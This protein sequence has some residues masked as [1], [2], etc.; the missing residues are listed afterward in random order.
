MSD[1]DIFNL[2]SDIDEPTE[3]PDWQE[4]SG[5]KAANTEVMY[6]E[7]LARRDEIR[8]QLDNGVNLKGKAKQIVKSEIAKSVGRNADYLSKRE[9]PSLS[10]FIEWTNKQL[11]QIDPAKG[12]VKPTGGL[13]VAELKN[14]V[15]KLEERLKSKNVEDL[16]NNRVIGQFG[17][18]KQENIKLSAENTDL[19]Y[20]IAEQKSNNLA[21]SREVA[22]LQEQIIELHK[23]V[24]DL[25]GNPESAPT[26]T[27]IK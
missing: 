19:T 23:L 9:F 11:A 8:K 1:F 13:T 27:R 3:L 5:S 17:V 18:L 7:V 14:K 16:I 22:R 2:G 25:G 12:T 6:K 26:F 20:Q 4:F 10:Q 24:R 21:L 15:S